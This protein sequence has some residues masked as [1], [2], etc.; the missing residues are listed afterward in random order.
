MPA[1]KQKLPSQKRLTASVLATLAVV[2]AGV[3]ATDQVA[4]AA[5]VWADEFDGTALD[6]TRWT[7]MIGDGSAFGIPGWGNNELQYYTADNATVADGYLTITAREQSVGGK[8]YTSARLRT[9]G[10][11]DWTYGRVEIRAKLPQGQGIWP[12]FWMLP[13]NNVYGGWPRSG[14]IDILETVGHEPD[15]MYGTI[16]YGGAPPDDNTFS[17]TG[18]SLP[19]GTLTGDFHEFVL[20]WD[21]GELRWYFDGEQYAVRNDWYTTGGAFP[22]PF[23]QEFHLLVNLAVGGDWPGD[24]DAT[25]QFPQTYVIDYVRVYQGASG[26]SPVD[27]LFDNMEHGNPFADGWFEFNGVAGGGIGPTGTGVRADG[28]GHA[29]AA[30]WGSGGTPGFFGGFG[31]GH[32]VNLEHHDAFEFW[33]DPDPG[34]SYR[35]EVNLQ[36][37]DNGDGE[38][39]PPADDEFQFD[40][41]VSP[42]GPCAISGGGWQKVT[43]PLTDFYD[44]SSFLFGGNGQLD[45]DGLGNGALMNVVF[46]LVSTDGSDVSFRTDDWRFTAPPQPDADEDGI[47][48]AADNCLVAANADQRDTDSDG[49]GNACDA[50]FNADCVVN[51]AD[52]ATIKA[53][54]LSANADADL[55]GDGV[56]NFGDLAVLKGLFLGPPG[57]AASPNAC[58]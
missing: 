24:P 43:I 37:D 7:P 9:L 18:L 8:N 27:F 35:L 47:P 33:I 21:E 41:V 29:L 13:S 45:A 51:F 3:F 50:D 5:L 23:D 1:N 19:D 40:C 52:L 53:L 2:P 39:T 12:A 34:Q 55:T 6:T 49:I 56:V 10:K 32:R 48:D 36:D 11:G 46:A 20:E 25:T 4:Q 16:H 14:E 30:S 22:A 38:I 28:G 26:P 15:R 57:P 42:T 58:D 31:R 44:D 17:G 54:F